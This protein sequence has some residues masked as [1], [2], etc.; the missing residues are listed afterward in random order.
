MQYLVAAEPSASVALSSAVH[1][2]G[3][4]LINSCGIV[5]WNESADS[6]ALKLRHEIGSAVVVSRLEDDW[7][8]R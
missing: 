5:P 2:L 6:L 4:K 8:Y 3:G 1:R 7:S